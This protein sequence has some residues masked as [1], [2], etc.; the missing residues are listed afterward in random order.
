MIQKWKP[1]EHSTGPKTLEGKRVSSRNSNQGKEWVE[2]RELRRMLKATARISTDKVVEA[3]T[4]IA[5]TD[6]QDG[7]ASYTQQTESAEH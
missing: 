4:T 3:E 5:D 1:W 7:N 2:I 6:L